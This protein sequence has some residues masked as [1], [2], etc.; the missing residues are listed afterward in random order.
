MLVI[1][2]V[3]YI[4]STFIDHFFLV[5]LKLKYVYKGACCLLWNNINH[6]FAFLYSI[7]IYRHPRYIAT[8]FSEGTVA[9]YQGLTVLRVCLGQSKGFLEISLFDHWMTL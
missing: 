3:L 8:N 7:S 4:I 6:S 5:F 2:N 9:L 1:V